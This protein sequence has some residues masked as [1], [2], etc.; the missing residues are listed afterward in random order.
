MFDLKHTENIDF[1]EF[2]NGI[3]MC[4]NSNEDDKVRLLFSLYDMDQDGFIKKK[5]MITMVYLP[6]F[7]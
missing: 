1:Y 4:C 5:E 2:V 7:H 6:L 3:N